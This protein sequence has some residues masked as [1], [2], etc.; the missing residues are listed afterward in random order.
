[1][2]KIKRV[3]TSRYSVS[4]SRDLQMAPIENRAT[5]QPVRID[6]L[7]VGI[8]N[9]T[10]DAPHGGELHT[11]GDELLYV[12]SGRV[13][14]TA[15]S[16]PDDVCELSPGECCIVPKGEWHRVHLLEPT[17]LLH[18]TPGPHGDHRPLS[19]TSTPGF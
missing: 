10:R 4:I 15:E 16:A 8:A 3:D 9:A 2:G 6:G 18:I 17:H 1:M 11:D 12:I 14:V 7:T 13:R 19:S 5:R